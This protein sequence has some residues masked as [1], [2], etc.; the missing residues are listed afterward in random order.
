MELLLGLAVAVALIA[1]IYFNRRAH[2]LDINQDGKVN[3]D[4]AKTAVNNT[5]SGIT[6]TL[7]VNDDGRI[8]A[9]DVKAAAKATVSTAKKIA[10]TATDAAKKTTAKKTARKSVSKK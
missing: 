9:G 2:G 5:V 3:L 1:L 4:D 6:E 7:D 8:D 10:K